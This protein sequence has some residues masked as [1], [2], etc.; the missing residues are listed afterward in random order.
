MAIILALSLGLLGSCKSKK[1]DQ[2]ANNSEKEGQMTVTGKVQQIENGKDGYMATLLDKDGKSFVA[3]I[4]IINLQKSGAPYKRYEIGDTITVSG[5]FW[6]DES[7]IT[8][9]TV[10]NLK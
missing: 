7:G 9:I 5:P 1:V 10:Q 2:Q 6:K 4:S 8:H 3:T